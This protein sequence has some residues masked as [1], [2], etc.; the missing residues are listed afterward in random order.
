MCKYRIQEAEQRKLEIQNPSSQISGS[1]I[2]GNLLPR[3]GEGQLENH[4]Q[5]GKFSQDRYRPPGLYGSF[6]SSVAITGGLVILRGSLSV[7]CCE[8]F[9]HLQ[10][11]TPSANWKL[12]IP[13]QFCEKINT[14]VQSNALTF[15]FVCQLLRSVQLKAQ[16]SGKV[17]CQACVSLRTSCQ[18]LKPTKVE[19]DGDS[20]SYKIIYLHSSMQA[21]TVSGHHITHYRAEHL[22]VSCGVHGPCQGLVQV[23]CLHG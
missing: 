16:L 12:I 23:K 2:L 17:L 13:T 14:H 5:L 1:S 21:H 9:G 10:R 22:V 20:S 8:V 3:E 6:L 19:C 15:V 4:L 7:K 11:D 18:A